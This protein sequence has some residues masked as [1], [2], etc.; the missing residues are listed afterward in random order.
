MG[1]IHYIDNALE[2]YA[3]QRTDGA[4]LRLTVEDFRVHDR[5]LIVFDHSSYRSA[6]KKPMGKSYVAEDAFWL[7]STDNARYRA[8]PE[9][10]GRFSSAYGR[11]S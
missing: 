10:R 6:A 4:P 3:S 9:A 5:S 2:K 7:K 11:K 8:Q 1:S